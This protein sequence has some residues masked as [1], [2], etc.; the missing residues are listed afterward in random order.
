[1]RV[2]SPVVSRNAIDA[3][4]Q[5][6]TYP[7]HAPARWALPLL[8]QLDARATGWQL[9]ELDA[10]ALAALWLPP[11]AGEACHGDS[12]S[13]SD[14][15]GSSVIQAHDWLIAHAGAYAEANPSCWGRITHAATEPTTPLVVSAVSVGDRVKPEG[16]GLVVVDGLH[17][18]LGYWMAGHRSC[19][20]YVPI[21]DRGASD[22]GL[23]EA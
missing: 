1:M 22:L 5:A 19:Q 12:M 20:A 3:E 9:V 18:A 6:A 13:L 17:R 14:E 23:S 21:I 7:G 11:H 8:D 2:I 16:A 15:G 4:I 10:D